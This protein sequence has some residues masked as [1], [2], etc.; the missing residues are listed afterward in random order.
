MCE[1]DECSS[2]KSIFPRLEN[3]GK[4]KWNK[5]KHYYYCSKTFQV[6]NLFHC[7]DHFVVLLLIRAFSNDDIMSS[8]SSLYLLLNRLILYNFFSYNRFD[9]METLN[10]NNYE[11][12]Y[13]W[14]YKETA[15]HI[16]FKS[17]SWIEI[18]KSTKLIF[19]TLIKSFYALQDYTRIANLV[20]SNRY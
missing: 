8:C 16:S 9:Y 1:G 5:N 11:T 10:G 15:I 3:G 19:S 17:T 7:D 2:T 4:G 6:Y 13:R 20:S 14:I 12:S 18:I